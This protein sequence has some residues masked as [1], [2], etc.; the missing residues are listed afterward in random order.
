MCS[1]NGPNAVTDGDTSRV[2]QRLRV[3]GIQVDKVIEVPVVSIDGSECNLH[4]VNVIARAQG[5]IRIK[6]GV[7]DD[8][9]RGVEAGLTDPL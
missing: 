9:G 2:A 8:V 1:T 7:G 5:F 3:S 4:N 6:V